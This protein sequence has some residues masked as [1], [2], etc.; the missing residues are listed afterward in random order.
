MRFKIRQEMYRMRWVYSTIIK[1]IVLSL[2]ILAESPRTHA[3]ISN[4]GAM[5][6]SNT[7]L[8]SPALAG[9]EQ[10]LNLNL[11][12]KKQWMRIPGSPTVQTITAEY[13]VNNKVGIG[14]NFYNDNAGLFKRTR[15]IASYAYHLPIDE[16]QRLH[17]GISLG[18]MNERINYEEINGDTDDSF[19]DNYNHQEPTIDGDFGLAY[20]RKGLTIQASM[21]NL[22]EHFQRGVMNDISNHT[23]FFSSV[24]HKFP[25][26]NGYDYIGIEPKISYRGVNGINNIM[27]V[28]ANLSYANNQLNFF[29]MYHSSE[30]AT[31]GFGFN[32]QSFGINGIYT[33]ATRKISGYTSGNFEINLKVKLL[34]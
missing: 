17:F 14:L 10:G 12:Y 18:F 30:N 4:M 2:T 5:Y 19:I 29:G 6:F 27:D 31:F 23:T 24:S 22:K 32:Y 3:Q 11:G 8:G 21:P 7:Y 20:T 33:T 15:I 16:E 1:I 13:A 26:V 9:L 34:Q 28:G 25:L